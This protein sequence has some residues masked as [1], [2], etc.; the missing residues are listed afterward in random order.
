M[1]IY[2]DDVQRYPTGSWSHMATD[3]DLAELHE[4]AAKIGMQRR[5]FQG[6]NKRHPHYDVRPTKRALA[7][8]YGA[9]AV[10]GIELVRRCTLTLEGKKQYE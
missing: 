7:I 5:W 9:V 4:M 8:Q 3:G 1:T 2:V 10:D 6:R